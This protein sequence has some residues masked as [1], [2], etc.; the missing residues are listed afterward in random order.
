MKKITEQI[1][2][3]VVALFLVVGTSYLLAWSGPPST[4][5]PPTN[6]TAGY[7]GCDAPLNVGN[8]V[9]T[10]LG[11]LVLN[12][13]SSPF[14]TGFVVLNGNVGIG[15]SSPSAK[16]GIAGKLQIF[17]GTQGA[18]KILISDTNGLASWGTPAGSGTCVTT[19]NDVTSQ[20][21]F[22][23]VYHNTNGSILFVNV[24]AIKN[25]T[26]GGGFNAS[27]DSSPNPTTN[28]SAT[29]VFESGW[30]A[31]TAFP[32]LPGN[33]YK[34][35]TNSG[36]MNLSKWVETSE[37]TGSSTNTGGLTNMIVFDY[38]SAK[39]SNSITYSGSNGVYT[40]TAPAGITK[41]KIEVWGGGQ[42]G[43]SNGGYGGIRGNAGGYARG[44]YTIQAG[45]SYQ[46]VVGKG[47]YC[48]LNTG[49]STGMNGANSSFSTLISATGGTTAPG[50]GIGGQENL[51]GSTVVQAVHYDG[52][53]G[54]DGASCTAATGQNIGGDSPRGAF[55]GLCPPYNT[56]GGGGKE[57]GCIN[58]IS[59]GGDGRITISY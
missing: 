53:C 19:Q 52:L 41:A 11:S 16:L 22:G 48:N 26:I 49:C 2:G 35:N 51:S 21:T 50:T 45:T 3:I 28:V 30:S 10:K 31:S 40:W 44:V 9:Q 15:T 7:P 46:I 54:G 55:G 23:T 56:P 47:G 25:S 6:C 59:Q 37:C 24:I 32:V 39:D 57:N 38:A 36:D 58:Y 13:A 34:I 29:S 12:T 1:K 5:T 17:D 20:R 4:G 42:A 18:G 14:A 27:T 43:A 33:Y 8:T